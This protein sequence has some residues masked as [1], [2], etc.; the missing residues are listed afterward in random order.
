MRY[1]LADYEWTAIRPMLPNKPRG[2]PRVNDCRVLNGIFGACDLEHLGAI[3]PRRLGR[4]P[5][6]TTRFVR[7]RRAGVWGRIIDAFAAAHDAAVQMIDTA[8]VRVHQ[9]GACITKNRRQLMGRS[10][11]GLTSKI[12]AL[13]DSNGL[14]V[15]LALSPGGAHDVRLAG[16]LLSR[17]KSGSMLLADRGYDAD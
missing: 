5:L 4:T 8:I 1:E 3:C 15:R 17:L 16:K 9:H 11:G 14:P 7:W 6:D 10:R 12:H 13:V 2:V